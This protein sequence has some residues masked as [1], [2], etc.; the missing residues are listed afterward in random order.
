MTLLKAPETS[1]FN[2]SPHEKKGEAAGEKQSRQLKT[3]DQ[4]SSDEHHDEDSQS[5][6]VDEREQP[7]SSVD[8]PL[9]SVVMCRFQASFAEENVTAGGYANKRAIDPSGSARAA[10]G[11]GNSSRQVLSAGCR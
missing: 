2:G 7:E 9:T 5:D 10:T 6:R 3:P 1:S 11:S 8:R 4:V